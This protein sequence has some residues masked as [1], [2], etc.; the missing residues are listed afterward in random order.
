MYTFSLSSCPPCWPCY[1]P[2]PMP[3]TE[4]TDPLPQATT[5]PPRATARPHPV[6]ELLPTITTSPTSTIT[7]TT[8][9]SRL[10][11]P[12]TTLPGQVTMHLRITGVGLIMVS[13]RVFSRVLEDWIGRIEKSGF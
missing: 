11:S 8:R 5:H 6:M 7:I 3:T 12:H 13:L 4:A 1:P 10:T 2:S 9:R